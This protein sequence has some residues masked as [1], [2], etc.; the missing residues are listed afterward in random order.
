MKIEKVWLRDF[1]PRP[2]LVVAI[3]VIRAFTT[4]A[5]AFHN[6]AEKIIPA[7]HVDEA[8][9][10]Q[11]QHP[12][13]LLM[14]EIKGEIIQG[15]DYG[16]SPTQFEGRAIKGSTIV[17]RTTCGTQGVIRALEE[18][19]HILAGSFV[20]A[21]ATADRI[22][23]IAPKQVTLLMTSILNGD[24]DAALAD[25]L[26]ELLIGNRPDPEP[27]LKRVR[28]QQ[29]FSFKLPKDQMQAIAH[30]DRFAFAIELFQAEPFPFFKPVD[31]LGKTWI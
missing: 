13:S 26:E 21:Q 1:T 3:D 4:A 19:D 11:K 30:L 23:Q 14:G 17:Q 18:A 24:E 5:H 6:G 22:L 29:E 7:M 16:N 28:N 8:F 31:S 15:F 20:I 12:S 9:L 27:F 25:Y 2:G 10:I